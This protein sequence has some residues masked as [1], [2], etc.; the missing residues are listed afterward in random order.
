MC[1][2]IDD[3]RFQ[4]NEGKVLVRTGKKLMIFLIIRAGVLGREQM[5]S[6]ERD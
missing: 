3:D 1:V 2:M 4:H 6:D 5:H